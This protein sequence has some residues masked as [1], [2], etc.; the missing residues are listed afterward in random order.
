MIDKKRKLES[1]MIG[2]TT[3]KKVLEIEIKELDDKNKI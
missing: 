1:G 3:T 2:K